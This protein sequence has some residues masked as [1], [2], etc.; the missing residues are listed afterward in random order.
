VDVPSA[1]RWLFESNIEAFQA[2][3]PDF[4]LFSA[5]AQ[6]DIFSRNIQ[7]RCSVY[8]EPERVSKEQA[9]AM[10]A[11]DLAKWQDDP[12]EFAQGLAAYVLGSR[13]EV[14]VV[15]TDNVDRLDLA[16]Q[17]T[18]FNVALSFMALTK[19]FVILQLRDETYERFKDEPLDTYRTGITF[20]ISPP[21]FIGVVIL[22]SETDITHFL[23][24]SVA[25]FARRLIGTMPIVTRRTPTACK[26]H[27]K[28]T[29]GKV[30]SA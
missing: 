28:T 7:K 6:R 11:A 29:T 8:E 13:H 30:D 27:R 23:V 22:S 20:H 5:L 17:L 24:P 16:G 25:R 12:K 2:E 26:A 21:R 14:L 18:G 3:N 9:A 19:C 15:V 4:D 10:R 1:E